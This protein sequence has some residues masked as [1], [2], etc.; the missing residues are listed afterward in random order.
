[1]LF[2]D[3]ITEQTLRFTDLFIALCCIAWLVTRSLSSPLAFYIYLQYMQ[4]GVSI[5]DT[6][7]VH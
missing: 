5:G 2:R 7:T 4:N 6:D 1:M 3:A